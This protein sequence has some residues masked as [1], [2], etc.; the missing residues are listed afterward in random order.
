M[1]L[2]KGSKFVIT[3][4]PTL[5]ILSFFDSGT[6]ANAFGAGDVLFD[7]ASF[8]FPKHPFGAK[9]TNIQTIVQGADQG[10]VEEGLELY[11]AQSNPDGTSPPSFG[12]PD[13]AVTAL[14]GGYFR[15]LLGHVA[16]PE[17]DFDDRLLYFSMAQTNESSNAVADVNGPGMVLGAEALTSNKFTENT[18][19]KLYVAATCIGTPSF[20]TNLVKNAG[21]TAAS[22]SES[23][24]TLATG[25]PRKVFSIGDTVHAHDGVRVGKVVGFGSDAALT[26]AATKFRVDKIEN[27]LAAA[28][29]L[30]NLQPITLRLSFEA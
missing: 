28:D 6:T 30:I 17:T 9:L 18:N 25:D 22:T 23:I 26:D 5:P 8:K 24:I 20:V 3:V 19:T 10:R 1:K 14:E 16:I 29:E 15:N 12:V 21:A 7:W 13:S 27:A 11:F 2:Y 4:R